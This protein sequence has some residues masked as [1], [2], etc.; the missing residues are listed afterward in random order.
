MGA[1]GAVEIIFKGKDVDK[2]TLQ[3]TELF[4]N[5][6]R[7]AERGFI[8]DIIAPSDTRKREWTASPV[9]LLEGVFFWTRA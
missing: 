3:Y 8:D 2:H 4:A 7:A 6:L 5:P 1:K 9:L